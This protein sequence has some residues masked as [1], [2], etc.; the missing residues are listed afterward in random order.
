MIDNGMIK[1]KL[2]L[3]TISNLNHRCEGWIYTAI[4]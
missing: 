2:L 3:P 1:K 4:V